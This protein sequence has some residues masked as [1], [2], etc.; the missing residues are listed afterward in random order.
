[1]IDLYD[2][3]IMSFTTVVVKHLKTE[4]DTLLYYKLLFGYSPP[5]VLIRALNLF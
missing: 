5:W 4:I 1:M 3:V 2:Y